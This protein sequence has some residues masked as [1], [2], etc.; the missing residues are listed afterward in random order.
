MTVADSR[1][2]TGP[3]LVLDRPGRHARVRLEESVRRARR[4]PVARRRA[5][6]A[7][8]GGLVRAKRSPCGRSPA[9]ASLALTAPIDAL[10]AAIELN[11]AAWAAGLR[12]ARRTRAAS[13]EPAVVARLRRP[14]R[15]ERQPGARGLRDAARAHDVTFLAGEEPGVGRLGRRARASGP[16]ARCPRRPG[17]LGGVH[18][19]PVALV[20]GS[21]GKTTVVRLLAA[22]LAAAGLHGGAHTSTD[23]VSVGDDDPAGRGRLQRVRAAR[24][25]CSAGRRSRRRCSRPRAA[26]CCAAGSAVDRAA[27]AVVTNIADDHLG[28]FGVRT[29]RQLADVKLLVTRAARVRGSRRAER[30]RPL[31]RDPRRGGSTFPSSG[32]RSSPLART[33]RRHLAAGGR[34]ALLE[35]DAAGPGRRSD[36]NDAGA[37]RRTCPWRWAA[38]PGTTWPTRSPRW[39]RPRVL[40]V[41]VAAMRAGARDASAATADDNA[42]SGQ[43]HRAGRCTAHHRLRPQSARDG[44]SGRHG[45]RDAGPPAARAHRPGGRPLRRSHPGAGP[46]RPGPP[47]RPGGAEG[48]GALPARAASRAR[49][50]ASWRTS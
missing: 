46:E 37:S 18:D 29:S 25:C 41:P 38:P 14:S 21:N 9:G 27:V 3:S 32:S 7:R 15:S 36:A 50:P 2:L 1:R 28:E 23:G 24:G 19:V 35:D 31:L 13:S 49:F 34:A 4:R 12:R 11:E 30:R 20:T 33:W 22:M 47:T 17:G 45:R 44:R 43:H 40:G 10:Y 39:A 26:D 8:R 42:R 5:P 48:D 16:R 6:A